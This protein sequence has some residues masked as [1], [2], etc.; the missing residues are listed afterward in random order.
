M[1]AVDLPHKLDAEQAVLGGIMLDESALPKL[2]DW[3]KPEDFYLPAHRLIYQAMLDNAAQGNPLDAVTL[4]EWF[5]GKGK[6]AVVDDGAYLIELATTTPSAASIDSYAQIVKSYATRRELIEAGNELAKR[7]YNPGGIDVPQ[8]AAATTLRLSELTNVRKGDFVIARDVAREWF[9]N[10]QSRHESG[11]T[12]IGLPTPWKEYSARIKGLQ[13]GRFYVWAG[14]PGMGKSAA[15][16]TAAVEMA[17]AN[18]DQY[19]MYFSVEMPASEVMER[20]VAHVAQVPLEFLQNPASPNHDPEILMPRVTGAI[21][22]INATRLMIDDTAS[23]TIRQVE[24]RARRLAMKGKV[25]GVF[26]DHM[27]RMAF[28]GQNEVTEYGMIAK[29]GKNLSKELDCPVVF[30]AQLNRS[31]DSRPDKRP[32]MSDLRA[33]GEIEQEADV[34]TFFYRDE[35]YT[36]EQSQ[37]KGNIEFI[38]EKNRSGQTGTDHVRSNLAMGGIVDYE[39]GRPS[40]DEPVKPAYSGF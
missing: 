27:H 4:G 38:T 25:A 13:A 1:N 16:V 18:P 32:I 6:L 24:S 17:I 26:L 8:I 23:M 14:R 9:N 22:A 5:A 15:A 12:L 10:F 37:R 29:G 2:A 11:D 28:I 3:I 21:R 34:I 36:K 7:G 40:F 33:S 20:M 39:R 19:V 35:Y 30:L 31:V